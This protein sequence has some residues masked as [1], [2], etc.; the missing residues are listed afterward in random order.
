VVYQKEST[1][2]EIVGTMYIAMRDHS[3]INGKKA[4]L[5]LSN[6]WNKYHLQDCVPSAVILTGRH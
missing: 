1:G 5:E 4:R 2:Q 6:G 3:G